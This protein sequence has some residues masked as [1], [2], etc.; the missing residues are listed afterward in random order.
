MKKIFIGIDISSKTLDICLK[1]DG[2]SQYF[3]INNEPRAIRSFFKKY[4]TQYA[5]IAMENT[6]H[7]NWN[8]LEVLSG[9]R[10]AV[11]VLAP[12]HLKKSLG[13]ARGKND[14]IDSLRIC[15][16]IENNERECKLWRPSS[17]AIRKLKVLLAE[18]ES[19]TK[20]KGQLLRQQH[21]YKLMKSIALDKELMK[22]NKKLIETIDGQIKKIEFDIEENIMTDSQLKEKTELIRSVPGV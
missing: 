21:D 13:L 18:R 19:R 20:I 11:Y 22:L 6:G 16:F 17:I 3:T 8:L 1:T 10:S 15:N 2:T 9:L 4:A 7:Y 5:V 14:K 12:L